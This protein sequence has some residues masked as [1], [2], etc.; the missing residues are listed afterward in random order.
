MIKNL[1]ILAFIITS[2]GGNTTK[3]K[4]FKQEETTKVEYT[5]PM[6]PEVIREKPGTCPV[7]KMDLVEKK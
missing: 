2:C 7:C 4:P 3:E 6:H 1:I 5:C